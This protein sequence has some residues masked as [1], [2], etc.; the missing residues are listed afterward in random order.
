MVLFKALVNGLAIALLKIVMGKIQ[1]YQ[2]LILLKQIS[3]VLPNIDLLYLH[4]FQVSLV[5]F[6]NIFS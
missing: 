6:F 5:L 1:V 4:Y 3:K 2:G